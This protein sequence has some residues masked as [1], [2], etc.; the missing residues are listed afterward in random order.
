MGKSS[1]TIFDSN[2]YFGVPPA[3]DPHAITADPR[4]GHPG[5]A[6]N[7]IDTVAVYSLL[8]NSPAINTGKAILDNGGQ[9]ILGNKVP[10]CGGIDR[11]AIESQSCPTGR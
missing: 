10:S 8:A 11:G 4:I 1:N 6:Q 3:D 5:A 7:G 2:V 9:D